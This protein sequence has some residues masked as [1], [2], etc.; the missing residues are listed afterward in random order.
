MMRFIRTRA[1]IAAAFFIALLVMYRFDWR[2][3]VAVFAFVI[4]TGVVTAPSLF[5]PDDPHIG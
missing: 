3:T 2:M 1:L 4:V 5:F